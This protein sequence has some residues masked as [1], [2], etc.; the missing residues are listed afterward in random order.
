MAN[1]YFSEVI[2]K[3]LLT[4]S[5][6]LLLTGTLVFAGGRRDADVITITVASPSTADDNTVMAFFRFAYLVEQRTEGRVR[7]NV[8]HSGQLGGQRDNVEQVQMG[9]IEMAEVNVAVLSAFNPRF[10]VFDMPYL[11]RGVDH[12]Q[13][14]LDGGKAQYFSDSLEASSGI[15]IIGWMIRSPRNM[16]TSTR[17]VHT[18]ADFSGMRVRIME[19][20]VHHRTFELLGAVPIPIA[21][22][23]R[24][25]ALQTGVVDAAENS[26]P[27]II[28]QREYE[29]TRYIS[30]TEHFMTPNLFA[31]SARFFHSLPADIQRIL[32][33]SADEAGRYGTRL[34]IESEEEAIQELVNRGMVFNDIP[35]RSSFIQAVSP[36]LAEFRDQIGGD[37][38]DAFIR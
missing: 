22:T 10:M 14:L 2:V 7:V 1:L 3:K 16:Y 26:F 23:E 17:P 12:L 35:D 33:Q 38:I 11:A 20:P 36:I 9:V 19:S 15:K 13:G 29:V 24:Y 32:V 6:I 21:A 31:I 8:M 30:R 5:L 34:D 27:L 37:L 28:A 18:A 4:L 25:M